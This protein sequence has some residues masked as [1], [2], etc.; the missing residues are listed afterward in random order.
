M[1]EFPAKPPADAGE[2]KAPALVLPPQFKILDHLSSGFIAAGSGGLTAA[3]LEGVFHGLAKA[4]TVPIVTFEQAVI[5][6]AISIAA[7]V[8]GLFVGGMVRAK[9]EDLAAG[10]K[11][12]EDSYL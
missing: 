7:L 9:E 12:D 4:E 6:G 3:F 8:V 2:S 1:K 10:Q 5:V 11:A